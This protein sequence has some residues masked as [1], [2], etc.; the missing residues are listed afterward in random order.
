MKYICFHWTAGSYGESQEDHEHYHFTI[1]PDGALAHGRFK[2]EDN[3]PKNGVS[4]AGQKPGTYAAHCGGGN[5]WAIG[6]ALRGMAGF[7]GP[8]KLGSYPLKAKQC[9]AAWELAA[10][11][12]LEYGIQIRPDTVFSHYE[13]GQKHPD[14]SSHGKIDIIHLPYEPELMPNDVGDFIRRKVSWYRAKLKDTSK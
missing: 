3:I 8:S 2:P 13:F 4:L 12:S 10:K 7:M 1:G 5:S 9:E 14:T 6:I 11:L